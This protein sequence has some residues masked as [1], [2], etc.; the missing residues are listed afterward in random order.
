MNLEEVFKKLG[1]EDY[2]ERIFN[3]NSR[4]EL[5]HLEQYFVLAEE[6]DDTEWFAH[7]FKE[8]VREAEKKWERP[9][10]VF[11]HI[12]K[13]FDHQVNLHEKDC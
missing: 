2:A 13:I 12:G 1:I 3:S 9:E 5:F 7:W 8:T 6:V 4:G 11:Q 10:S